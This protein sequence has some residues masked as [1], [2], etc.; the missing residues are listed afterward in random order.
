[1]T[2]EQ[3]ERQMEF[4][5]QH[6]AQFAADIQQL[7]EAQAE[8]DQRV[9]SLV[10]VSLSLVHHVEEIDTRLANFISETG[11]QLQKLAESQVHSDRRLDALVD[12]VRRQAE[13]SNGK[14]GKDKE[15]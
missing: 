2:D 4:L 9:R 15:A 8:T 1:M 12:I 5:L 10:D 6:Q 3:F 7:K 13:R 11:A 14:E